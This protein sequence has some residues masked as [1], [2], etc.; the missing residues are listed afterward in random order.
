MPDTYRHQA[1]LEKIV[2]L[3]S[4]IGE[5]HARMNFCL[6]SLCAMNTTSIDG[7]DPLSFFES[8][9]NGS[10]NSNHIYETAIKGNVLNILKSYTGFF[11]ILCEPIQ[12][13]LDAC[14]KQWRLDSTY[15]PK[16]RIEI[17]IQ[18]QTV[19]VLDNGTGMTATQFAHCFTPNV[20]Y[21]KGERLRGQKGVGAT[22][23][24]Y[25]FNYVQLKTKC[26]GERR[27][28]ILRQGRQWAEDG[29]NFVPR[30]KL[31]ELKT[32]NCD[33]L[34]RQV[35]G[36]S[37]LIKLTSST[38]EKPKDLGW[39]G[40]TNAEQWMTL[41]RILTPLGGIYIEHSEFKPTVEI[42]VT[43]RSGTQT[44]TSIVNPEYFYVHDIDGVRSVDLSSIR[45]ALSSIDG[46]PAHKA[47]RIPDRFKNIECLWDFWDAKT[48]LSEKG[49]DKLNDEQ[50]ALIEQHCVTVYGG[51][52]STLDIFDAFNRKLG[53]NERFKYLRGGL[54]LATDSMPQGELLV[55]PLK[56]YI[57]YQRN[58][59]IVVHFKDGNPDLG[60]KVF[61]P[62]LRALA[63]E[64]AEKITNV[65]ITYRNLLKPDSGAIPTLLPDKE[66]HVWKRAQEDWRDKHPLNLTG[67][68]PTTSYI[69]APQEEQDV[70]ALYHQLIGAGLIRGINFYGSKVNERYDAL[71]EMNYSDDTVQYHPASCPLGV[72]SAIDFPYNSEPKIL[73]YKFDL[74]ALFRDFDA[75]IKFAKHVDFIVC[76]KASLQVKNG[77]SIHSYLVDDQGVRR[78]FYGATH[79]LEQAGSGHFMEVVILE[80]LLNYLANK[81]QESANQK[82]KY[83]LYD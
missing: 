16:I 76:W 7:Y 62:E 82:V 32:F 40:A 36:T 46:D 17:S 55:I 72:T 49:L 5:Q 47:S 70:I 37:I 56:R 24:A 19:E 71:V 10:A 18:E 66:L 59:H 57:G 4:N 75:S 13:A 11:D 28:A 69:S 33:W 41:L 52:V 27:A 83:R 2:F 64:I 48:L 67:T 78:V 21:K 9:A 68:W 43:D 80:E 14:E 23:L 51:F 39:C 6:P 79:R 58:A 22:F 20:S 15:V 77:F 31:E 3:S 73:E 61:Q 25:G 42:S 45:D 63:E 60:R 65:F 26:D 29:N 30:P 12:N 35:S 38:N 44:G 34:D 81:T 53:V 8:H 54:Q 1:L 50:K 74:D